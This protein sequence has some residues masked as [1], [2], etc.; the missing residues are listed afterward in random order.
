[1]SDG[2]DRLALFRPGGGPPL[3]EFLRLEDLRGHRW[4]L[5]TWLGLYVFVGIRMAWVLRP[6]VRA[7]GQ[8]VQFF[9]EES[10]GNAY[11]V[12]LRLVWPALLR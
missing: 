8:A 11:E 2:R 6:F 4:M 1:L 10:W 5:W 9:R 3:A 12:V 7:P